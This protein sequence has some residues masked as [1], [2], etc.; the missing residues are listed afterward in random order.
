[1][2]YIKLRVWSEQ[3][4][5]LT[6]ENRQGLVG[7]ENIKKRRE[8]VQNNVEMLRKEADEWHNKVQVSRQDVN[9]MRIKLEK[10]R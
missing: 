6:E 8:D 3:V 9:D 7:L 1:M 2:T 5:K 10:A 4:G